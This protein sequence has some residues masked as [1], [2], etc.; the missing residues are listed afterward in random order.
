MVQTDTVEGES[1]IKVK[2]ILNVKKTRV[3]PVT[4]D[5]MLRDVTKQNF[6]EG[7]SC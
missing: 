6:G 7:A 5:F 2:Y 1:T 3:L 4:Y